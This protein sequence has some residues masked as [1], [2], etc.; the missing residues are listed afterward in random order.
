MFKRIAFILLI[1]KCLT[2][3]DVSAQINT[4]RMLTIGKNALYFEDY[5]LAIQYFNKVI[6][7]KPYLSDPYFYRGLAKYYLEDYNGA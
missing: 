3:A 6:K 7:V 4:D 1:F 5:V 2:T